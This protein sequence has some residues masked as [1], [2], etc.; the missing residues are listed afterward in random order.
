MLQFVNK[1]FF[2]EVEFS[3]FLNIDIFDHVVSFLI[4][5]INLNI[6]NNLP[7]LIIDYYLTTNLNCYFKIKALNTIL[8]NKLTKA[9]MIS[10]VKLSPFLDIF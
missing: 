3:Y 2:F 10:E 8:L 5:K 7:L 9:Y 4:I 1:L 6:Y